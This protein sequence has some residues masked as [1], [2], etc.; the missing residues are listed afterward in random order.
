MYSNLFV[1]TNYSLLSSLI[2]PEKLVNFAVKKNIDC[3]V[4]CDDKLNAVMSFYK[5][6]QKHNI[7][8]VVAL[9]T[10]YKD[11]HILLFAKNYE[12]YLQLIKLVTKLEIEDLDVNDLK[13]NSDLFYAVLPFDSQHLFEE[14]SKIYSDL[15]LAAS[16]KIEENNLLNYS[17]KIR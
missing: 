17:E 10:K 5:A 8:P 12:S 2:S 1:K 13:E 14:L 11:A 3:L 9:D 6:C 16:S 15:Y 7:K 4:I